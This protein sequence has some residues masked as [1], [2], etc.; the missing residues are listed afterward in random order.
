[1]SGKGR[2]LWLPSRIRRRVQYPLVA[3]LRTFAV[4]NIIYYA[5]VINTVRYDVF[6]GFP[7]FLGHVAQRGE[8]EQSHGETRQAVYRRYR[9]RVHQY[10]IVVAVVRRERYDQTE[11]DSDRTQVLTDGAHPDLSN[12]TEISILKTA[13]LAVPANRNDQWY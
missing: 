13:G 12:Q 6:H 8:R 10:V 1:M 5:I 4:Y 9:H 2:V 11:G 3:F 7:V